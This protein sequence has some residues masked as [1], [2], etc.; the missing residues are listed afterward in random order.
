MRGSFWRGML[1]GG[2]LGAVAGLLLA[3]R[4]GEPARRRMRIAGDMVKRGA[5]RLW[6]RA[7]HG[8]EEVM[9]RPEQ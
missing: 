9:N 6:R 5:Q 7:Q 8:A 1:A 3:P 2:I 4:M